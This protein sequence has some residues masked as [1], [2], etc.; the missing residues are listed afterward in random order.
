MSKLLPPHHHLYFLPLTS[1]TPLTPASLI[2]RG[3]L[4]LTTV[5]NSSRHLRRDL[6][7]A[8]AGGFDGLDDGEGLVICD[9]AEDDMFAVEPGGYDGGDKELGTVAVVIALC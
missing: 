1:S 5:D 2:D 8:R 3:S 4:K 6:A 9:F 7:V